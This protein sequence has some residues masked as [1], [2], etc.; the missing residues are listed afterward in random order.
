MLLKVGGCIIAT[1]NALR[2]SL[3]QEHQAAFLMH[4]NFA[5]RG[6]VARRC[7]VP[8]YAPA[9]SQRRSR[10]KS[11]KGQHR[12]MGAAHTHVLYVA[13]SS[14]IAWLFAKERDAIVLASLQYLFAV[15]CKRYTSTAYK[16]SRK[17]ET[18]LRG[19]RPSCGVVARVYCPD[20]VPLFLVVVSWKVQVRCGSKGR[21][22]SWQRGR[23]CAADSTGDGR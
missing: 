1:A 6:R 11:Q 3:F 18:V 22:L 4:C 20:D 7:R 17:P 12:S 19:P 2:I 14:P 15:R 23:Y 5:R 9:A 16:V 21:Q 8:C 10:M 13:R